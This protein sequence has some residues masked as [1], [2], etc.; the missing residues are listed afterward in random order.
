MNLYKHALGRVVPIDT[1]AVTSALERQLTLTKP[2]GSLGDLEEVANR[3]CGI[4]AKV[5]SS[6]PRQPPYLCFRG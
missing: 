6:D 1:K 3:L 4:S 5:S 2:P